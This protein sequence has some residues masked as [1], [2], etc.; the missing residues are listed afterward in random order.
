MQHDFSHNIIIPESHTIFDFVNLIEKNPNINL[1]HSYHGKLINKIKEHFSESQQQIFIA[2]FYCYLN[3]NQSTDFVISLDNI[4]KWM[5]FHQKSNAKTALEKYFQPNIDYKIIISSS[6]P[7]S[8]ST[9]SSSTIKKQ[10]GGHN[11]ETIMLTNNTFKLFCIKAGT[12]KANEIHHYFVK[13]EHLLHQTSQEENN[14][15][16]IQLQQTTSLLEQ[17]KLSAS[18]EKD[19]LREK[20]ILNQYKPNDQC[21]YYGIIDNLSD[22]NESL[23]KFGNSNNLKERIKQHKR[24]YS[25]FRLVNAFK[26][27]N[28]CKIENIIKNHPDIKP[29]LRS[30]TI[31]D[32]NHIELLAHNNISFCLLDKIISN[33]IKFY[34]FTPENYQNIVE[35]NITFKEEIYRIQSENSLLLRK[36]N[37]LLQTLKFKEEFVNQ[38]FD[39]TTINT[40]P[41]SSPPPTPPPIIAFNN[42]F[43]TQNIDIPSPSKSYD[44]LI[45][46]TKS[47]RRMHPQKDGLFHINNKTYS[48]L[49]GSREEV[50]NEI[51]YKTRGLLTK[52][53]LVKNKENKI[54]SKSKF[55]TSKLFNNFGFDT[56]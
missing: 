40:T 20:T 30:I 43:I 46:E 50:W 19:I 9:T 36:Y 41:S 14:E 35:E 15:L 12:N 26:V 55:I 51:A 5:G 11:K 53:K 27:E 34:E 2:S 52:D 42:S 49:F 25:N 13:L 29:H 47:L 24:L 23:I 3:Y 7:T 54:V 16:F 32:Q 39:S 48:K 10:R 44:S 33:I 1:S 17:Q 21:V 28:K 31:H 38:L 22:S 8:S 45:I 37:H 6:S 4:W 18:K 56:T